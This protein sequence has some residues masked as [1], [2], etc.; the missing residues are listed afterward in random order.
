MLP[1]VER[2]RELAFATDPFPNTTTT[3]VQYH[4]GHLVTAMA[5]GI[6]R[7]GFVY[8]K[9]LFFQIDVSGT[10]VVTPTLIRQGVINPGSGVA[11]QMPS[12]DEDQ[13]GNLGFTWIEVVG[14]R[15]SLDVGWR[16]GY[17]R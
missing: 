8:P 16:P 2:A 15:V 7:D 11:V 10:G 3:Q 5:S 17:E 1:H 12:V 9:G 13:L 6:G 4:N 14:Y